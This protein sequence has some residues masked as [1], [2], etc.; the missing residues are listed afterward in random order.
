MALPSSR[1]RTRRGQR[2]EDGSKNGFEVAIIAPL[3]QISTQEL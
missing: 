1:P 2:A 3:R